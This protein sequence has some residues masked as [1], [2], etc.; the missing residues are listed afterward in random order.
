MQRPLAVF[1]AIVFAF[2]AGA[3]TAGQDARTAGLVPS[4]RAAI[5]KHDFAAGEALIAQYR[6]RQGVTSELAEA[7]SWLGRGAL[8]NRELDRAEQYALDAEDLSIEVLKTVRVNDDRHLELALGAAIETEALVKAARG[9]RSEAIYGLKRALADYGDTVLNKRI[10]KNINALSLEG[11]AAIPLNT[12][13]HLGPVV[14]TFDQLKG[15]VVLLFFWAHWCPDCKAESP[16]LAKMIDKY[17]SQGLEIV[18]PTQR[19]GY[20]AGGKPAGPD[21]EL[22]YII[23][24]RDT[25]YGFLRNQPVPVSEANHLQYGVSSTPTLVFL[26]RAGR[27]H[28]YHPG[29]MTE[30]ELDTEIRKLLGQ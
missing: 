19:Y 29:R 1:A 7:V 15:K 3:A 21:E 8:A 23:Q 20:V 18:A 24:I 22:K 4:V 27:V 13:E 12:A 10:H 14:P 5:A 6:A 11:Q 26:D 9:A 25:Y 17:R 28:L 30:E 2:G 16:I